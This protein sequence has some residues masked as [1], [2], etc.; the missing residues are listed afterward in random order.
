MANVKNL[1]GVVVD[2]LGVV[3]ASKTA[4]LKNDGTGATVASTTTD[5]NG[6][7]AFAGQDETV[8]HR[9]EVA[10]GGGSTQVF[11]RSPAG[12]DLDDAYIYG[13]LRTAAAA[14]VAF[15]GVVSIATGGLTVTAGSVVLPSNSL[16]VGSGQLQV[17]GGNVA[18]SGG[19][20]V[21]G[22]TLQQAI[23][24]KVVGA[25]DIGIAFNRN[26]ISGWHAGVDQS[27]N[28]AFSI[29]PGQAINSTTGLKITTGGVIVTNVGSTTVP[30]ITRQ[31]DEDTGISIT[32]TG[33]NNVRIIAN[34]ATEVTI[35]AGAIGFFA[36]AATTKQTVTG[37]R[38]GNAALASLLTSLA[39]YGLITDSSSA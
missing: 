19:I 31:G 3:L 1:S 28:D 36:A 26:D 18:V 2:A 10:V 35:G 13:S 8:R 37:S 9:V 17:T 23:S 33:T 5:A 39:N 29:G 30:G 25:A 27:D 11:R 20:L 16:N 6:K 38:G 7:W 15:G 4:T 22:A 12:V 34:G 32:P 24:L 21:A 14:T